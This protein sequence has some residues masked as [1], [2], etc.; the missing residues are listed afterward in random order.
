[1][2]ALDV[3]I[4]ALRLVLVALLYIFLFAVLRMALRGTRPSAPQRL[5]LR[6]VEPGASTL[7]AGEILD[8][9]P[10]T[11]LGRGGSADLVLVD[12]AVSAE[13][14]RLDRVGRRWVVTDLGST[15]GTRLNDAVVSQQVPLAEGDVLALG[16]VRLEVVAR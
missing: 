4:L 13:H 8:V 3:V 14:A 16:T 7:Q 9:V 5:A 1:V 12:N 15:N 10:G 6:V 2:D 11:T